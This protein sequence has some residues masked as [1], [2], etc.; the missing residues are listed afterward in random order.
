M[1]LKTQ[2]GG[3]VALTGTA[4][5]AHQ[6]AVVLLNDRTPVYVHGLSGWNASFDLKQVI[7]K[8]TLRHRS[9]APD[10][11]VDEDGAVSHGM[12]GPVFVVEEA[13]WSLDTP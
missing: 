6:G 4:R 3:Q 12:D 5:N 10:A 1:S 8:G 13:T 7:V 2:V 9:I 11:S